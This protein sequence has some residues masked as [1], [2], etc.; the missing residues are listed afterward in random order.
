MPINYQQNYQRNSP[1][2][3]VNRRSVTTQT[4]STGNS[5]QHSREQSD[6]QQSN[7]F[8]DSPVMQS[9]Q[10]ARR[11][12][13][14]FLRYNRVVQ[15]L[16]TN[17]S[18]TIRLFPERDLSW[19]QSPSSEIARRIGMQP[20]T[21]PSRGNWTTAL[22]M[23]TSNTIGRWRKSLVTT[24]R[25]PWIFRLFVVSGYMDLLELANLSTQ[26]NIMVPTSF[27]NHRT[28]GGMDT[29]KKKLFS[30]TTSIPSNWDIFSRF[31]QT[32]TALLQK[33]REVLSTFDQIES[34]SQAITRW[35]KYS[36]KTKRCVMLSNAASILFI[37]LLGWDEIS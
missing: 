12:T 34:L 17:S 25:S 28:N 15:E 32:V 22:Q 33:Q 6:W 3:E 14:M 37:F 4:M 9:P 26:G 5:S 16:N 1:I 21:S 24:C 35:N 13:T 20:E 7:P 31:G 11:Q 30:S 27:S 8:L 23:S 19:E 36:Q 10:E 18:R 2:S 29:S